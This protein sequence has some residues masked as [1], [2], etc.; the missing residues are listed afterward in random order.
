MRQAPFKAVLWNKVWMTFLNH[1]FLWWPCQSLTVH[2]FPCLK[3]MTAHTLCV[4]W[5]LRMFQSL[6]SQVTCRS[7]GPIT[8]FLSLSFLVGKM[9]MM[10]F[11][12]KWKAH[13]Q[14]S[15]YNLLRTKFALNTSG[16]C[17]QNLKDT[18]N[19]SSE[20][21]CPWMFSPKTLT[22]LYSEFQLSTQCC[23]C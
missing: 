15:A 18:N 9:N 2:G 1:S 8:I 16:F 6:E 21:P 5:E 7:V 19:S 22:F 11:G 14:Q 20:K 13:V 12:T 10:F 4:L 3:T 17:S 23:R